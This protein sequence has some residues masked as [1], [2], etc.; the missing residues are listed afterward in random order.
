MTSSPKKIATLTTIITLTASVAFVG[1]TGSGTSSGTQQSPTPSPLIGTW[2]CQTTQPSQPQDWH[3]QEQDKIEMIGTWQHGTARPKDDANASDPNY[4]Y[5]FA[6]LNATTWVYIQVGVSQPDSQPSGGAKPRSTPTPLPMTYFVGTS[7]DGRTW[8]IVYPVDGGS[9]TYTPSS[10]GIPH[11]F[12]IKRADLTQVCD[13]AGDYVPAISTPNMTCD[14]TVG[15]A[16]TTQYLTVS[17]LGTYWWQGVATSQSSRN[18]IYEY[19]IISIEGQFIS[20]E[21]N[22]VTGAYAIAVSNQS[23]DL[24]NTNWTEVYPE[25]KN[26]FT[27]R[28]VSYDKDHLPTAF[29]V[30]FADGYQS[31]VTPTPR[32]SADHGA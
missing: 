2:D 4:D 21:T 18:I 11:E 32:A 14:N 23:Q 15:N 24:N 8:K 26:A 16:K 22:A 1:A 12:T 19:N 7:K 5:Y 29:T 31:C 27:F 17:K 3:L 9:Y 13:R 25:V 10:T 30:V 28:N 6:K 20:I